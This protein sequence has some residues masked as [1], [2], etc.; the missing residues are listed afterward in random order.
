MS[1]AQIPM[2][3]EILGMADAQGMPIWLES[4]WAIDA[5]LV[6]I[7]REHDDIDLAV[8]QERFADFR[9]WLK[10]LGCGPFEDTEYGVL[11]RVGGT[12]LDCEPCVQF[13]GVSELDG[14]PLG[15]R[16]REKQGLL[17]R[18]EVRC[19]SW[20]AILWEY[21]YYLEEV[22]RAAWRAKDRVAS[23]EK[24][25]FKLS[26]EHLRIHGML[27]GNPTATLCRRRCP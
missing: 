15:S 26:V 3:H 21:F 18:V 4:G 13:H 2:I 12:L 16:P 27:S 20:E 8:P 11:V 22:P 1:T 9:Q 5:R 25:P 24:I 6:R 7:T 17:S 10:S 23:S 19:T 14:V